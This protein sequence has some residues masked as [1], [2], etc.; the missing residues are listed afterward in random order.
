[1]LE[2]KHLYQVLPA[3]SQRAGF[4]ALALFILLTAFF[5]L[6]LLF[7][8]FTHNDGT[9]VQ[10]G[11]GYMIQCRDRIYDKGI[12]RE[13]FFISLFYEGFL[14]RIAPRYQT[15]FLNCPRSPSWF[16]AALYLH[17]DGTRL[18]QGHRWHPG[19]SRHS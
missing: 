6:L 10:Q 2:L 14:Q 13:M 1:M 3:L 18:R 17:N 19:I 15:I 9:A 8:V 4:A 7:L 16:A 5:F 11:I 12:K